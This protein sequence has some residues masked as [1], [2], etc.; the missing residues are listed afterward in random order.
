MTDIDGVFYKIYSQIS[1]KSL[2][3]IDETYNHIINEIKQI[4][5]LLKNNIENND[6]YIN[7]V[8][9]INKFNESVRR[10]SIPSSTMGFEKNVMNEYKKIHIDIGKEILESYSSLLYSKKLISIMNSKS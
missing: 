1:D 5:D 7:L 9:N 6:K 4:N 3:G 8:K 10:L 2:V